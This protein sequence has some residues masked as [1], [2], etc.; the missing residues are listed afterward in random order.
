MGCRCHSA[1]VQGQRPCGSQRRATPYGQSRA[2]LM[3]PLASCHRA[4]PYAECCKA[5][6]LGFYLLPLA[7]CPLPLAPCLC[8]AKITGAGRNAKPRRANFF[9]LA[10]V[11]QENGL[12]PAGEA[13]H[14]SYGK[15]RHRPQRGRHQG[16][17]PRRST[18]SPGGKRHPARHTLRRERGGHRGLPLPSR[19]SPSA[20]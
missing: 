19:T 17:V 9:P 2:G 8:H 11:C 16:L 4:M 12:P 10:V 14:T 6:G 7:S 13:Q 20:R 5:V 1:W 3:R 15:D 18:E